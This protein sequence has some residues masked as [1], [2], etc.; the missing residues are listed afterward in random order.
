MFTCENPLMMDL[1]NDLGTLDYKNRDG[2]RIRLSKQEARRGAFML[3]T[4]HQAINAGCNLCY[5]LLEG[6]HLR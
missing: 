1:P 5:Y 4:L 3:C 6:T 2:E